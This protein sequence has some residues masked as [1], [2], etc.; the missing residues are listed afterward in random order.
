MN[1]ENSLCASAGA[2]T[3]LFNDEPQGG[4]L[5]EEA[6]FAILVLSIGR[7]EVQSS[8]EQAAM[9]IGD[10]RPGVAPQR[11]GTVCSRVMVGQVFDELL[12]VRMPFVIVT[13]IGAVIVSP[14]R[15]ADVFVGEQ[16]LTEVMV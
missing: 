14:R 12:D 15:T 7:V 10:E 11:V 6:Q 1:V 2:P 13:K 4:A 9:R 5:I 3:G 8:F 16:E